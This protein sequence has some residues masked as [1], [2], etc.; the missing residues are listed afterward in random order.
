MPCEVRKIKKIHAEEVPSATL[1]RKRLFAL[2]LASIFLFLA[3]FARFFYVQVAWSGELGY[4]AL[5]QWM[6]E[7]PVV[8]E[9]SA[10]N[11]LNIEESS[12]QKAKK[13]GYRHKYGK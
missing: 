5:D 3:V 13:K 1:L 12:R 2:L 10:P 4:R 8:A 6:R 7:I 9:L 11:D